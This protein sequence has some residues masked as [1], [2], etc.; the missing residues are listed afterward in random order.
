[1]SRTPSDGFAAL[2]RA[3]APLWAG[4]AAVFDA[5]WSNG[6]RTTETDL[7]WIARQAHK[8]LVDGVEPRLESLVRSLDGLD[9]P[10][11]RDEA[12]RAASGIATELAHFIAFADAYDVVRG[13]AGSPLDLEAVRAANWPEN[14]VLMA[15][16]SDH[17][18]EH[19]ELGHRAHAFTEGGYCTLYAAGMA[20]QGGGPVDDAVASACALVYDD[21]FDH[22]MEGL[23]GLDDDDLSADEWALLTDLTVEQGRLRIEMRNAQF[24]YP[25]A[26][27]GLDDALAG[28]L[29]PLAFDFARAGFSV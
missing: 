2:V 3:N 11:G 20:R 23:V 5:Y 16:R 19:G 7:A 8:E 29:P 25:L 10:G 24:S 9:T 22:M 14:R 4:E 13:E 18:A 21:E 17:K 12:R 26:G 28:R 27:R 15:L 6:A 1:M